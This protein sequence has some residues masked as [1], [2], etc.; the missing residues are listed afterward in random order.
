MKSFA[1]C[2]SSSHAQTIGSLCTSTHNQ[3][4]TCTTL[5]SPEVRSQATLFCNVHTHFCPVGKKTALKGTKQPEPEFFDHYQPP[6]TGPGTL[7]HGNN[8]PS[9]QSGGSRQR[10]WRAGDGHCERG[11]ERR[12]ERERFKVMNECG[13]VEL[14]QESPARVPP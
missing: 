6:S 2:V 10:G 3:I 11:R 13:K 12:E 7:C 1:S 8:N 5:P 9:C 14:V 4:P